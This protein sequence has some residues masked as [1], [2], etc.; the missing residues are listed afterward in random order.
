MAKK[1][2]FKEI[3]EENHKFLECLNENDNQCAKEHYI[4][5]KEMVDTKVKQTKDKGKPI[6]DQLSEWIIIT[7]ANMFNFKDLTDKTF[8]N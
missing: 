7:N 8:K 1:G 4:N 5:V 6:S 3:E 2:S